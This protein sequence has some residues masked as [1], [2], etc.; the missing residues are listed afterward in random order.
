MSVD[1]TSARERRRRE[2]VFRKRVGRALGVAAVLA[3]L[4]GVW[5]AW[6][7]AR[8]GFTHE[9]RALVTD[10]L[11]QRG[12]LVAMAKLTLDP[13]NGLVAR[14]VRVV[15]ARHPKT[16]VIR[17]DRL[18]LDVSLGDMLFGRPFLNGFELKD[19][20]LTLPFAGAGEERG[21][22]VVTS[23][24]A[25][26]SLPPGQAV[27]RY[28]EASVLGVRVRGAGRLLAPGIGQGQIPL[29]R[30]KEPRW[31]PALERWLAEVR[32]PGGEEPTLDLRFE[33]DLA[34]P[35]MLRVRGWFQSGPVEWRTARCEWMYAEMDWR[36]DV[37]EIGRFEMGDAGRGTLAAV[38]RWSERTGEGEF[39]VV[40][41]FD[42]SGV[43]PWLGSGRV[44]AEFVVFD[45]PEFEMEGAW[46]QAGWSVTGNVRVGRFGVRS[47]V[48]DGGSAAF[49]LAP[50]RWYLR[51][52]RIGYRGAWA[53][54]SAMLS[55]EG[56]R[57]RVESEIPAGEFRPLADSRAAA[58]ALEALPQP[59][60]GPVHF[61]VAGATLDPATWVVQ[62]R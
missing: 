4:F 25:R 45:R 35:E 48:F 53:G 20:S 8:R 32:Y 38:L 28:A 59:K 18:S 44:G 58:R 11:A 3:T 2:L 41:G 30:L 43:L 57:A 19:A 17:I 13:I 29:D 60:N 24:D 46:K 50:G 55:P 42:M 33:G 36:A 1:G 5:S 16:A 14:G 40:S 10:E 7:L 52:A 39:R 15:D 51:D 62:P 47:M 31:F 37:F 56:F 23:L 34:R 6:Y 54:G 49:G 61:E 21:P 26:V 27:V 9:W 22:L 12:V